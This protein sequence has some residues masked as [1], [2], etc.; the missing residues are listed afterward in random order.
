M[1]LE[2]L[3]KVLAARGLASRRGAEQ[4]ILDG[5]VQVNGVV[6]REMGTKVDPDQDRIEVD[7]ERLAQKKETT[8]WVVL[9]KPTGVVTT[10]GE[11]EGPNVMSL[12]Q[13]E[14]ANADLWPVGRLDKDSSGLLLLCN[15]GVLGYALM[16]PATHLEKEYWVEV[17]A[18]IGEGHLNKWRRGVKL[19]GGLTL[20]A[21]AW[22][23][24]TRSF[25]IV[26]TQGRNRQI[27][28][29]VEKLDLKVLAL[30]RV[31]LGPLTIGDSEP[32]QW[33]ALNTQEVQ[34]L[35]DDVARVK[36]RSAEV[37]NATQTL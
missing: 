26:L 35:R 12:L 30:K 13:G 3:Q 24:G 15:D 10:R 9:H 32:G 4:L 5:W 20:P 33:R 23:V 29:M 21:Q 16:D 19:D 6:V 36:A 8:R 25:H 27:R 2:R 18:D 31:R 37:L 17:D 14:P 34:A 22:S 28:R 1:A 11:G 7:A